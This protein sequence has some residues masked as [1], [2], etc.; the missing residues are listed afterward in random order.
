M[1]KFL[2]WTLG[3]CLG[4][5]AVRG[6]ETVD[7]QHQ[8]DLPF[9][10]GETLTY[11]VAWSIFPAGRVV[12]TLLSPG[13][14]GETAY[15][16]KTTAES[17]GVVSLLY[18]VEDEFHSFFNPS[19]LCSERITKK[20]HEGRRHRQTEIKFDYARKVA[21]LDERDPTNPNARPKHDENSIPACVEDVVSAFY[22]L[23]KQ[24]LQVGQKIKLAVNDGSK[25]TEVEAD[26]QGR[27]LI[28]TGLGTLSALRVEPK[29][30]GA[31][32]P[33]KGR[34][35]IWFSDDSRHLPLRIRMMISI[36]TITGTL[37]SVTNSGDKTSS[38]PAPA[39]LGP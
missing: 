15:E 17:R 18:D 34:M 32:Y 30:F 20:V 23:R 26:V 38:A 14:N 10:P 11:D 9:S 36:G 29:V 35:L 19:T 37:A 39:V 31:L 5:L 8:P 16:V 13:K 12:A 33:R 21:M 25:T 24:P 4:L 7:A 28:T 1:R 3:V 27:G 2:A 22:Y 6:P